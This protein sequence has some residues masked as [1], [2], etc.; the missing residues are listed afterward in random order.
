M[1]TS[2]PPFVEH[3]STDAAVSDPRDAA[4]RTILLIDTIAELLGDALRLEPRIPGT[5]HPA[6]ALRP[7]LVKLAHGAPV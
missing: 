2:D 4:V 6:H 3:T 1:T 5:Q 7:R